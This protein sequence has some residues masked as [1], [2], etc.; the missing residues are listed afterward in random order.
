M[1]NH[2]DNQLTI[3]HANPV[4]M[5]LI[6]SAVSANKFF[7]TLVPLS[8]NCDPRV[9]WG[10]KWDAWDLYITEI[11]ES[12]VQISFSSAWNAPIEF[13]HRLVSRGYEVCGYYYEPGCLECGVFDNGVVTDYDLNDLD[14]VPLY[15]QEMFA[16]GK[17]AEEEECTDCSSC[18]CGE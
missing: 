14:T 13:Y 15:V 1:P 9:E 16:F 12:T 11:D 10:T 6:K 7:D 18:N 8:A 3:K 5:D 4:Q 17:Y 2:C